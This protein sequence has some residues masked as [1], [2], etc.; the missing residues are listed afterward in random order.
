MRQLFTTQLE[1]QEKVAFAHAQN[2]TRATEQLSEARSRV[3]ELEAQT[4][5]Q[6]EVSVL[7]CIDMY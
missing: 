6:A 3:S 7:T 5:T 2:C 1:A 4:R